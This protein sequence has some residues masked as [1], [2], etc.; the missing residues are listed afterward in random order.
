[1][2]HALRR[3]AASPAFTVIALLTL[4][5]GIGMN[6]SIFSVLNALLLRR[7]SYP[8]DSRLIRVYRTSPQSQAWPHSPANFLD[9]QAQNQAFEKMAALRW[10]GFSFAEPGQPAERVTGML[11]TADFFPILGTP[12]LL[13]R[14]FTAEEDKPGA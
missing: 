13:G 11:V 1:M 5:L 6:T 8:D 14:V 2:A 9:H 4:A 3:L 7:T 12:P 10:A